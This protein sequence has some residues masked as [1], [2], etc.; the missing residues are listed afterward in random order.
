MSTFVNAVRNQMTTT[1]NGMVTRVSSANANVD[2]FYKIG[3]SRGKNIVP[4]FAAAYSENRDY[5]LRIAQWARDIRGGAGERKIFRD[6][7]LYL[8][9][10]NPTDAEALMKKTPLVGRFD[11]LLIDFKSEKITNFAYSILYKSI[12]EE[13]N[14]LAAKWMPRQGVKASSIRKFFGWSPKRYRK[15]LVNLTKVVETNMCSNDWDS[16]NFNHVPSRASKIYKDAFARHTKK[17]EEW[18]SKL[19]SGDKTA[20]VNASAIYP[21]DVIK[22]WNYKKDNRMM[23]AQWNA[24]PNYVG[25]ANVLAMVD[26]SGSMTVNVP[27]STTTA[28]DVALSLGLYCADKNKGPFKDTFLTFSSE[29]ELIHVQGSITDKLMQMNR[30]AW[31]MST[32]IIGAFDKILLTAIRNQV[33]NAEMPKVLLILSDMQFDSASVKGS[34]DILKDKYQNAGYDLPK[35]VYWNLISYDNTPVKFDTYGTALVS[36]FSPAIMQSVFSND[37]EQFTPENVMLKT[38]MAERY[39]Y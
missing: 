37:L 26:V 25:D 15:T 34:Y 11:D 7:L 27:N 13:K 30:S 2:L 23:E 20:K 6:I 16:I 18:V 35:I 31:Q 17:Y 32:N 36:G 29:P 24:L 39:N 21:Y 8:E 14:G 28:I 3:A 38:I 9:Q 5:A 19:V 22:G 33:P 1:L 4:E 10:K 12:V